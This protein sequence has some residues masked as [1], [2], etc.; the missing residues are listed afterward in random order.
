VTTRRAAAAALGLSVLLPGVAA[1]SQQRPAHLGWLLTSNRRNTS[2][3]AVFE[4][5]LGELGYHEGKN[6]VIDEAYSEGKLERLAP[7]S[8]DLVAR[9]PDVLFVPGPEA[10]LKAMSEATDSIPIVVCA[11]DYDPEAKGYVKSL[12]K[13]GRNITGVHVQQIEATGKRLELLHE[14]LPG[15]RR[16]AVLTDVFTV[17][18][19]V[20]ARK[21]AQQLNVELNVLEM[22]DYPYDYASIVTHARSSRSEAVL[23]LMSPRVFTGREGLLAQLRKHALPAIFGLTQYVDAGGFAAFGASI[24]AVFARAAAYV[25]KIFKGDTPATMPM[26]QPTEFDLA[27]NLK[28]AKDLG[29][30]IPQSVLL[31]ATRVIQ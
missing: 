17:D 6:L 19:L 24:D 9:K 29:I 22:R 25:D 14:L 7:L 5:R 8:L 11:I 12:A 1:R 3:S 15:A 18:Q 2:F 27:I 28:T 26:E 23:V 4:R 21:A 13:P 20:A 16:I 10:N 30:R 31:R